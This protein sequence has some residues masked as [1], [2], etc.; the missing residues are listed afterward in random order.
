MIPSL[1]LNQSKII[2]PVI[3]FQTKSIVAHHNSNQLVFIAIYYIAIEIVQEYVVCNAK[4]SSSDNVYIN[5]VLV[6][7][8]FNFKS[9]LNS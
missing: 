3:S 2:L 9:C 4:K 1:V 7:Q 6:F 5:N 8:A